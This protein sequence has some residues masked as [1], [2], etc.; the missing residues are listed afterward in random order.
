MATT[1]DQVFQDNFV[2]N[3]PKQKGSMLDEVRR[4]GIEETRKINGHSRKLEIWPKFKNLA[5]GSIPKAKQFIFDT[6]SSKIMADFIL[7]SPELI[8]KNE[9]F[10]K[11]HFDVTY[12]EFDADMFLQAFGRPGTGDK[13][14][15]GRD[16]RVGYLIVDNLV[17]VIAKTFR[18]MATPGV[19]PYAIQIGPSGLHPKL[20]PLSRRNKAT[21][22]LG[23]TIDDLP[24]ETW[25]EIA[26]RYGLVNI[27]KDLDDGFVKQLMPDGA[28]DL[29]NLI[30]MILFLYQ[31]KEVIHLT[32]VAPQRGF[33]KG[34][35]MPY[36]RHSVV[37]IHLKNIAQIRKHIVENERSSPGRH[38]VIPYYRTT[39]N[40]KSCD[41]DF[42]MYKEDRW[43]CTKCG[44]KRALVKSY[45]RGD[46]T[47]GYVMKH[48]E[49]VR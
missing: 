17:F 41:H 14:G 43:Q 46:A 22:L 49:V 3:R 19:L 11:P 44:A 10:A 7:E 6:D 36:M 5:M 45:E 8:F 28:G 40:D 42:E 37:T 23:S 16:W 25:Q 27:T 1:I 24:M 2:F 20:I 30:T 47:K 12:Y 35:L 33:I 48:Y 13:Q 29:R 15:A 21:V 32:D 4:F 39:H 38:W 18:D 9:Q 34:K 26:D 31:K